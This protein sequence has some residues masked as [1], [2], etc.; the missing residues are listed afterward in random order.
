MSDLE[1]F[2]ATLRLHKL[3]RDFEE[4]KREFSDVLGILVKPKTEPIKRRKSS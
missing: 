2:A 4:L 3:E 1:M